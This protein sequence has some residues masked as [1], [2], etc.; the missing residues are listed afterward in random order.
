MRAILFFLLTIPVLGF[1]QQFKFDKNWQFLGP[2]SMP[3]TDG[4]VSSAGIGP[5]EFIRLHP[6]KEGLMLAGSLHGGLFCSKDGAETWINAGSDRWPYS[7]CCW[8]DFHPNEENTWFAVSNVKGANGKPGAIGRD[9]GLFRT[10]DGGTKWTRIATHRDFGAEQFTIYG[11]RFHPEKP[12][13]LF[14]MTTRGVY[15]TDDC[16]QTSPEWTYLES[17]KGMAYDLDFLEGRM[18]VSNFYKGK[19]SVISLDQNSL[20]DKKVHSKA[21]TSDDE[22]RSIT[23]EPINDRLLVLVD[24][25]KGVDQIWDYHPETD[26]SAIYLTNQRVNFGHGHT[27]AVN[28]HNKKEIF[29]G[30]ST[31]AK[32]YSYPEG[33]QLRF[34]G[35]YHVDVEFAAYDPFDTS[36]FYMGTHGGVYVSNDRAESWTNKSVGLGIAEVMGMAV[37]HTDP[38]QVVI[39]CFHDGSSVLADWDKNGTYYWAN[40]NG[41]DA[42]IP[43]IDPTDNALVYT[44]NQYVGGGIYYSS[45]TAKTVQNIHQRNSQK[46]SG[47]EMAAALYPKT[48][49]VLFYNFMHNSGEDK[50][51]IDVSRTTDASEK[52]IAE[53]I[54]NFRESHGFKKYKVY[55]LFNSKYYP[56]QLM[57]YVLHFDK[58]AENKKVVRHRV[59]VTENVMAEADT[60]KNSWRELEMPLNNWIGDIEVDPLRRNILYVSYTAGKAKPETMFGDKGLIFSLK[61]KI[62]KDGSYSLRKEIDISRNVPNTQGGRYNIQFPSADRREVFFAT[63]TG[64]WMGDLKVMKGKSRWRK[65]GKGLPHC[66]IYGLDYH[67]E[68]HILT[69]GLFGRG[70]WR[71]YL[72]DE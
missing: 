56:D 67:P 7:A 30:N 4:F 49:K 72:T 46:T 55:G 61:Y 42:L 63:R 14:L 19:W 11:T 37:S 51:N 21:F 36:T 35:R 33:Q 52:R 1:S 64:V 8:A 18:Y 9:G 71:Y 26:S 62:A 43:L 24:Q 54:S 65:V 39:G 34:K 69:V 70:V 2:D 66:K 45:D 48:S 25:K 40:V 23:F 57:A 20:T 13:T 44:S 47:W 60:V 50:G 29:I 15:Y 41:G 58:D 10:K 6:K 27:F 16:L 17:T 31:R 28:P 38:N 3:Y 32:R 22:L 68:K 59:F 5:V 53:S 12:N